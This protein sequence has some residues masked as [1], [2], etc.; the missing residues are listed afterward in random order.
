MSGKVEAEKQQ[1]KAWR[2]TGSASDLTAKISVR[3][4]VHCA[5]VDDLHLFAEKEPLL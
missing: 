4:C 5:R 3:S 1:G 2:A